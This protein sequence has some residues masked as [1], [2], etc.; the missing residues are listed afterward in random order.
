MLGTAIVANR[1]NTMHRGLSRSSGKLIPSCM[2]HPTGGAM[3][4]F[5]GRALALAL[6]GKMVYMRDMTKTAA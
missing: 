4:K 2:T 3:V 1:A 6:A 5:A